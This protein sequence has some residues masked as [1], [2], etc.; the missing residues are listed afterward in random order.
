M[1]IQSHTIR[2]VSKERL[3]KLISMFSQGFRQTDISERTLPIGPDGSEER[4]IALSTT[5]SEGFMAFK[6]VPG[7]YDRP[8]GCEHYMLYTITE[9]EESPDP[10]LAS[11][12]VLYKPDK[13]MEKMDSLFTSFLRFTHSSEGRR[14][15]N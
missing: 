12:V 4:C 9:M 7:S 5:D 6:L 2:T 10:V 3:L 14:I 15:A 11:A 13:Q 8:F 1:I